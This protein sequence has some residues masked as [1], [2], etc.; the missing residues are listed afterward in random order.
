M[1]YLKII[2][3]IVL[4]SG[5]LY[6]KNSEL[7]LTK[8]ERLYIQN[9]EKIT[10]CV[11]NDFLP[12]ESFENGKFIGISAEFFESIMEGVNIPIEVKVTHTKAENFQVFKKG[13]CDVKPFYPQGLETFIPY[14]ATTPYFLDSVSLVTKIEQAYIYDVRNLKNKK[15]VSIKGAKRFLDFL[16][17]KHPYFDIREVKDIDTALKLVASGEV[18]G[19]V[20]TSLTSSYKIQKLYSTELKIINNL[21]EFEFGFGVLNSE[22]EM[23]SILNKGISSISELQKQTILN[24]WVATKYELK[25]DNSTFYEIISFLILVFL[26]MAFL[27]LKQNR[28]KKEIDKLNR[29]LE[30]KVMAATVELESKNI[31]LTKKTKEQN[32]LL[33]L[34]DIG[35]SVLFNWNNDEG[36][37]VKSV[38]KSVYNL[39]GYEKEEFEN[40]T[41]LYSESIHPDDLEL[42][43]KEVQDASV[44]HKNYFKHSPY[45]LIT[46]YGDITWVHDYT[47]ILRDDGKITNY[48]G[49]ISD[50]TQQRQKN[51]Q[52]LQQSKLAQMGDMIGMIA[53][54]WRQPLNA[55]SATGINLSLLSS[56]KMLED[57]NVQEDSLFIQEQC[58]K[59]SSTIDTFMDFV[60]P[61][62]ES[63]PFDLT[64]SVNAVLE[65]MGTQLT[66]H[67]IEVNQESLN[68]EVAI[69]GHEDLL[70]QVLINILSNARDAFED[71]E[72]TDKFIDIRI[73]VNG[74]KPTIVIEDNAGGIPEDIADKIFNPYFTTKEQG[75]GTGLGLY[76]SL[77][78]MKKSFNGN[79]KYT[80]TEIG[81]RFELLF[82]VVYISKE[83]L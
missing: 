43:S 44:S 29:E 52:L 19:Y 60:K 39:L 46:K 28:L 67:S 23:L 50:V 24:N 62:K 27:L 9:K 69:V 7:S 21:E 61:A 8:K 33:K 74:N 58:Q 26:F 2:I 12:Y 22:P 32:T 18:F 66:N 56:M 82:D 59:M 5:V 49:Y 53:H 73:Y 71:I 37:S 64:H 48:I 63:K 76:M 20:G 78:I 36:W 83:S 35:D 17:K 40:S 54:Q 3:T 41:I 79:L 4:L 10:I 42:V 25:N 45:R 14:S 38:S 34:F 68:D 15:L 16:R 77:D 72:C 51:E 70:E 55:I 81:S 30:N 31:T 1:K 6:A 57:A 65:I 47:L 80:Q 75:K 13:L 11:N